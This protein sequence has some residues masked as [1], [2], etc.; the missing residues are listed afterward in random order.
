MARRPPEDLH[1]WI[2]FEDPTEHRTWL[3]D[4]TFLRSNYRCIYGDGCLGILDGPAPELELGCCS[5]GAHFVDEEDVADVVKAFVRLRPDQMQ[6]HAKAT[7]AG[8][9]AP[10]S[11][12]RTAS[13]SR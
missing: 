7:R 8:S 12:A 9:S 10:A 5:Y 1:E 4:A 6:F 11:P 2:S 3:F 13:R